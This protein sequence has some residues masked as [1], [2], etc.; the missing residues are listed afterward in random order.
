MRRTKNNSNSLYSRELN[1]KKNSQGTNSLRNAP[2]FIFADGTPPG[3]FFDGVDE[4]NPEIVE[5]LILPYKKYQYLG[6]EARYLAQINYIMW[7][8]G[9]PEDEIEDEES[10]IS[11]KSINTTHKSKDENLEFENKTKK[12]KMIKVKIEDFSAKSK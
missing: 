1:Q 2:A 10:N 12:S 9:A 8:A 4:P 5:N 3:V 11:K 6:Y 7:A